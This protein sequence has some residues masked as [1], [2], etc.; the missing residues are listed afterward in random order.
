MQAIKWKVGDERVLTREVTRE[1][2][3]K[4]VEVSGDRNPVHLSEAVAATT[5][6][7]KCIA[8]GMLS[9]SY[10]STL[11]ADAIPGPGA[12]YLGQNLRFVRPVYPGDSITVKATVKAID[13]EKQTMTL[14]TVCSNQHGKEVI[15]G[16]AEVLYADCY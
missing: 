4:F 14:T 9:A 13:T 15:T 5:R 1:R 8:H 16:E 12:I 10:I 11:I 7:K 6:F 3:L 2:I